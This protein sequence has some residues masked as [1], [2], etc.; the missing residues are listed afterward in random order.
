M[1]DVRDGEFQLS[2]TNK[3]IKT[4]DGITG[5]KTGYTDS[6]RYCL[7][8][9]AERDGMGL[10]AT[11]MGASTSQLRFATASQLL[12]YGFTHYA[13][14]DVTLDEALPPVVV[15]G[16]EED[17]VQPQLTGSHHLLLPKTQAGEVTTQVELRDSVEA[18]VAA[19]DPLGTV[20]VYVDGQLRDTLTLTAVQGVE[21]LTYPT[22][23]QRLFSAMEMRDI[24]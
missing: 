12:D 4:Y 7:S 6:A 23:L 24:S 20:N 13:L 8:A 17:C 11:V 9:T 10:I 1:D 19:G 21:K 14:V 5:L 16:G 2:N 3:L 22:V 15:K 18:P